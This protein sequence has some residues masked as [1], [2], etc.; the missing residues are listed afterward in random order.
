MYMYSK[1]VRNMFVGSTCAVSMFRKE[2][3]I[4]MFIQSGNSVAQH[5]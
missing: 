5:P 1:N 4:L 3:E 2:M